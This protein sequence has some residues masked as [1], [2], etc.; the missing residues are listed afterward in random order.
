MPSGQG[1][2]GMNRPIYSGGQMAAMNPS[3][4]MQTNQSYV[5]YGAANPQIRMNSAGQPMSMRPSGQYGMSGP[6][7][8]GGMSMSGMGMSRSGMMGPGGYGMASGGGP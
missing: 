1:M 7:Q 2:P 3:Y 5:G 8:P 4:G 6:M